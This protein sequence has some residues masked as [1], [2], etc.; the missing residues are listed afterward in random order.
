M[1]RKKIVA[2]TLLFAF[3]ASGCSQT[4]D[5]ATPV[6]STSAPSTEAAEGTNPEYP[7]GLKPE[8]GAELKV[9][10][11]GG[12][13]GQWVEYVTTAFTKTYNIPV[14]I[15]VVENGDAPKKLQTD[16]PAG[17][18]AD[19]FVAPHDHLG[20]M[21][22]AGLILPNDEFKEMMQNDFMD[23]AMKG[24][25]LGD[26]LYGFPTGVETYA[27]YYNKK[28]VPEPPKTFDELIAI[29]GKINDP[30]QKTYGLMWE[31][32]NLYYDSAFFQGFGGYVFGK[33]GS[34][35]QDIGLN[36][37]ASV[38]ALDYIGKIKTVVPFKKEDVTYDI[39]E[40]L[41]KE[42][43]LAFNINGQAGAASLEGAVDFGVIPLPKLPNGETPKSFLG[44]RALYVNSYT[45]YPQASKLFAHFASSKEMLAKRF[46]ISG[47]LPPRNDLMNDPAI[48]NDP[49]AA[50]F[51]QQ[52]ASAIAMP[53]IPEMV[54][55]WGPMGT[56]V[57]QAW[58]NGGD[59]KALLD[60][61]VK[62][63][64]EA[65]SINK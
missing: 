60:E 30:K 38:N 49:Y 25:T 52:A 12:V 10:E 24:V 50:P 43:K 40:G 4:S 44:I 6:E 65:I 55:V 39:K 20:N 27:L 47:Q 51:L 1:G 48:A 5:P 2:F 63:I 32:G 26:T 7:A 54:N 33:N 17:L 28:L 23:S 16:G 45:K 14:K 18:A 11:G 35:A 59:S 22:S 57:T 8:P 34:D 64:R 61:A 9:W 29:A 13:N 3:T 19:V 36:N 31:M 21:A 53:S 41:F 56:A 58:N 46:E 62:Q 15:E 37:E 42:G